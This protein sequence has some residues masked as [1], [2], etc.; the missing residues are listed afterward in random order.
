MAHGVH[1]LTLRPVAADWQP[2]ILRSITLRPAASGT[3]PKTE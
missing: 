3:S 2:V 1:E